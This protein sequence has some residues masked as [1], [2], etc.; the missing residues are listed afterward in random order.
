MLAALHHLA[1]YYLQ[2]EVLVE[3]IIRIAAVQ[4]LVMVGLAEISLVQNQNSVV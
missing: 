4:E 3:I 1:V 2:V